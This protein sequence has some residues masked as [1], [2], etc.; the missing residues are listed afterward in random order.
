META[1]HA[2]VVDHE[3]QLASWSPPEAIADAIEAREL[4]EA[5]A[6]DAGEY[7]APD[8]DLVR[9]HIPGQE[10]DRMVW[11]VAEAPDRFP[12]IHFRTL[13]SSLASVICFG[14]FGSS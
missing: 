12:P 9:Q 3:S 7:Q 1:S 13:G 14:Y 6:H 11:R 5:V 8:L 10:I 4:E 2:G